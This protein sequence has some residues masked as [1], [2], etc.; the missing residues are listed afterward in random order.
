MLHHHSFSM[1]LHWSIL[2][3]VKW[4]WDVAPQAAKHILQGSHFISLFSAHSSFHL[5]RAPGN[6]FIGHQA[7]MG[8]VKKKSLLLRQWASWSLG[9]DFFSLQFYRGSIHK[10]IRLLFFGLVLMQ[11]KI[12]LSTCHLFFMNKKRSPWSTVGWLANRRIKFLTASC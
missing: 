8:L 4:T 11:W 9:L 1:N 12:S 5:I 3:C 7:L 2:I 6:L 10:I